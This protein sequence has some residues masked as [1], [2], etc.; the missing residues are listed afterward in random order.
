[1]SAVYHCRHKVKLHHRAFYDIRG[2]VQPGASV[3]AAISLYRIQIGIIPIL[4]DFKRESA[5]AR[6]LINI[7][8]PDIP[9]G[10][11]KKEIFFIIMG[12]YP[13][14]LIMHG[15][16]NFQIPGITVGS[17]VLKLCR[18]DV[19]SSHGRVK[20]RLT[21][22]G[23]LIDFNTRLTAAHQFRRHLLRMAVTRFILRFCQRNYGK[24]VKRVNVRL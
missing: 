6:S 15:I 5:N 4:F 13:V 24:R 23:T 19:D 12:R 1:M 11:A 21:G 7:L 22:P 3:F 18:P 8:A 9:A 2:Q 20:H 17:V 14:S 10:I 16:G